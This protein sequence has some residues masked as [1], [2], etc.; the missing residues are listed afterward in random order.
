MGAQLHALAALPSGNNLGTHCIGGWVGPRAGLNTCKIPQPY[1]DF[2][3]FFVLHLYY[4]FCPDFPGC[5]LSFLSLLCNSHN[6]NIH[7]PGGIRTRNPSKQSAADPHLG[8]LGHWDSIPG[9]P[10]PVASR[11]KGYA[12]PAD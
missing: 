7:A 6:T 8:P 2:F 1:R 4:F 11:Y 12:I 5:L 10:K 3:L 9:P